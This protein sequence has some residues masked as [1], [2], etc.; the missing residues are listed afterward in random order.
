MKHEFLCNKIKKVTDFYNFFYKKTKN[1]VLVINEMIFYYLKL[2]KV[3]FFSF[4]IEHIIYKCNF[5]IWI[6][7]TYK[8]CVLIEY[9]S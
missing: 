4:N 9:V 5:I 6:L 8:V 3:R 7:K 1:S 2:T